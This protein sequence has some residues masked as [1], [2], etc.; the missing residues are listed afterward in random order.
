MLLELRQLGVRRRL[1]SQKRPQ[2][3]W[4]S[5]TES[6]LAVVRLVAEGMTNRQVARHL[7]VSPHTVNAH[8]RHAFSKLD[9]PVICALNGP[10]IMAL[11]WLAL[12][13]TRLGALLRA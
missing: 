12:N 8:L 10:A 7:Y 4:E 2:T 3:G 11:Q 13:R 1:V 5:L 6:E 9:K